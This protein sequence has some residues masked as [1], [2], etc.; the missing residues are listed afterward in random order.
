MGVADAVQE[1]S[2][3]MV[4]VTHNGNNRRTELE[5]LR[6]ILDFGDFRRVCIRRQ[7]FTGY[8][9]F[10]CHESCRIEV[11]FLVDGCHYAHHKE[12]L[13]DFSSRVAHLG[14][15]VLNGNHFR[16]LDVLRTGDFHLRC[17]L[18]VAAL[19]VTSLAATAVIITAIPVIAFVPIVTAIVLAATTVVTVIL[20]VAVAIVLVVAA[21]AFTTAVVALIP[22]IIIV[23]ALVMTA[24][25]AAFM[26][27]VLAIAMIIAA[28]LV[29]AVFMLFVA[30]VRVLICRFCL[31]S[32]FHFFDFLNLFHFFGLSFGLA[33]L[34]R[35]SLGSRSCAL[36]VMLFQ[37]FTLSVTD[38]AEIIFNLETAFLQDFQNFFSFLVEFF[39]QF[40]NSYIGH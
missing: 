24:A 17:R 11:D 32:F 34:R 6:V 3:T 5:A 25:I 33:V 37:C 22:F 38:T 15:E 30:A 4:N 12:L 36:V 26:I 2:L 21:A 31:G 13:H 9:K 19:V 29:L 23:I 35:S 20:V 28:I 7:F 1:R 16:Q 18:L 8:A 14:S 10:G 39:G 27:A 40:I